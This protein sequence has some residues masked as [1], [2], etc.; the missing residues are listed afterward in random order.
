MIAPS[1]CYLTHNCKKFRN[2][3]CPVNSPFCMRLFKQDVLF[4]NS[5]LSNKQRKYTELRLDTTQQDRDAFI[6]LKSIE[7]NIQTFVK[8]GHNLFLYSPITG[9]GKTEW[10]LRLIQAYIGSIWHECDLVCKALFINVPRYLI[11]L[12]SNISKKSDYIEEVEENILTA[13]LVVFD[14]IGSKAGTEF[15]IEHLLSSINYRIDN[16]KSNV[17]TSNISPE[18]L[19]GL[20]GPRLTSRLIGMS[21]V[22][23]L[24]ESDKRGL[25]E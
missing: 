5:L 22:I 15:E 12:K 21:T 11:E 9:N 6:Q 4:E 7:N 10:S 16:G 18:D 20:L 1:E 25:C 24:K 17:Y 3:E 8:D 14:D 13:D 23:E 19:S 2:N